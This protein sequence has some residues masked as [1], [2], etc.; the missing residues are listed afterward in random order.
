MEPYVNKYYYVVVISLTNILSID[1]S[2]D[3]TWRQNTSSAVLDE[4]HRES[5]PRPPG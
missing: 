4:E 5:R 2:D 3:L 1:V